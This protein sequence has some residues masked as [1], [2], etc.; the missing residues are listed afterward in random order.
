[1]SCCRPAQRMPA[2]QGRAF[3]S[4][5][6][7][8]ICLWALDP[9][10]IRSVTQRQAL[11][12]LNSWQGLLVGQRG[13]LAPTDRQPW[14]PASAECLNDKIPTPITIIMRISSPTS[15]QDEDISNTLN[16]ANARLPEDEPLTEV[17]G[18]FRSRSRRPDFS[19]ATSCTGQPG[20]DGQQVAGRTSDPELLLGH[21]CSTAGLRMR[22]AVQQGWLPE[23][24]ACV[25]C[26]A[27]QVASHV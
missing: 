8:R 16:T 15:K 6:S 19:L 26:T 14:L 4:A 1:M 23:W 5:V 24:V 22:C 21:M 3:A 27:V 13:E 17:E 25:V 7:A 11:P 18:S 2:W 10:S 9:C 12:A 20:S